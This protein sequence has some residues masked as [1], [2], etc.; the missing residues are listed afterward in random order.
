MPRQIR[1]LSDRDPDIGDTALPFAVTNEQQEILEFLL[2]TQVSPDITNHFKRTPLHLVAFH[3]PLESTGILLRSSPKPQLGLRDAWGTTPLTTAQ[4]LERYYI[5]V[6][7]IDAGTQIDNS[8][9]SHI[10]PTFFAAVEL[11]NANVAEQ[12]ITKGADHL[13]PDAEGMTA[14]HIARSNDDVAVL[15][16]LDTHRR[17]L[18]RFSIRLAAVGEVC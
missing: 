2:K 6:A 9:R 5:A 3:N 12:L 15:R 7:L 8:N 14:K 16:T 11:G 13:G 18:L 17:G 10:R 4:N 1:T